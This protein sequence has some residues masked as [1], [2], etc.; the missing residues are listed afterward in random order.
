LALKQETP[1]EK[2][3]VTR[4]DL[5]FEYSE[6]LGESQ[7]LVR[8]LAMIDKIAGSEVPVLIQGE[9]GTGKELIARAIHHSSKRSSCPFVPENCAAIP[10][11]L[12]ESEL[13][14][15]MRGSFTGAYQDKQG[16]F[17][18]AD[19]GTLF[20]DE[21]GDMSYNM[22]KKLLRTLQNGEI[23]P[24]GGKSI[25]RVNVRIIAATNKDIKKA[26]AEGKFREDL[27]YRLNVV[28]LRLPPLRERR[29]DIGVLF[30]HFLHNLTKKAGIESVTITDEV[31]KRFMAYPW[32]GNIRE[33]QNEVQR[34]V[35]LLEGNTIVESMLS[36]E[37][38]RA[39]G[40]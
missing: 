37:I 30:E 25:K 24:I 21:V 22:Q 8:V 4:K 2:P 34:I 20:L 36:P 38:L 14:G 13:F 5:R 6:I 16:L 33:L 15:Y 39:T 10:E 23:R 11:T 26:M 7:A 31:K 17:E 19:G 18:M 35:A 12:L 9:S 27:F 40:G 28:M 29:E 3:Y 32:P 1:S